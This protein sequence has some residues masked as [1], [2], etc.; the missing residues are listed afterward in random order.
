MIF[1]FFDLPNSVLQSIMINLF[2]LEFFFMG[3]KKK[4]ITKRRSDIAIKN[5]QCGRK[6]GYLS[7]RSAYAGVKELRARGEDN[8]HVYSCPFCGKFHVGHKR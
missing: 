3:K 6:I 4:K 2:K 8:L 7:K 1:L 5:G